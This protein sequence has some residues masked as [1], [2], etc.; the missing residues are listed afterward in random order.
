MM[1]SLTPSAPVALDLLLWPV[2]AIVFLLW[3]VV[4]VAV[5]TISVVVR[6]ALRAPHAVRAAAPGVRRREALAA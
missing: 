1:A 4:A 3:I 5:W 6:L 2:E